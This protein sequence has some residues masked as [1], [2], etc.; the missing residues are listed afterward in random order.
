MHVCMCMYM[1]AYIHACRFSVRSYEGGAAI[2]PAFLPVGDG[3]ATGRAK[4]RALAVY[5]FC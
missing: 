3:R 4:G 2:G 5:L 1:Y